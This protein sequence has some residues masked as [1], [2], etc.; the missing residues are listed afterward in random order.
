MV[1]PLDWSPVGVA[2]VHGTVW[3][4]LPFEG[5]VLDDSYHRVHVGEAP[6]RL[7]TTPYGVWVSVIRDGQVVRMD[8]FT[9]R[10][11]RRVRLRP[12]GSEPE[13]LAYDGHSLWVVDQAHDRVVPVDP[14]TGSVGRAVRVGGAPRL[15]AAGPSAVW[16][17]NYEEGSLSRVETGRGARP[18][19]RTVDLRGCLGPQGLAEAGGVVWVACTTSS[20]VV[21]LDAHSLRRVVLLRG[22][23][24]A[25]AVT[26]KENRVY[27]V[28]QRG[29][30]VWAIDADA[31]RVRSR[32]TM[33]HVLPTRE[34][35]GAAVVGP[36]LVITHPDAQRVW[37]VP[38]RRLR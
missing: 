29:P 25:D 5:D 12:A 18:V 32:L 4:T 36:L 31:R 30:T 21:G 6:L 15:V 14:R 38:L 23:D 35:V 24:A 3:Y 9:D 34:N 13:G 20:T 17:S 19:V 1:T 11:D 26:A 8:P 16:V 10:V 7:V 33:G 27:V 37:T 22:P 2:G 28:G